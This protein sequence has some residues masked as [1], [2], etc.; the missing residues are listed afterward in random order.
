MKKSIWTA[1]VAVLAVGL[2]AFAVV[3]VLKPSTPKLDIDNETNLYQGDSSAEGTLT[4]EGDEI[5]ETPFS[6]EETGESV[7]GEITSAIDNTITTVT[8]VLSRTTEPVTTKK[9]SLFPKKDKTTSQAPETSTAATTAAKPATTSTTRATTKASTTAKPTETTTVAGTY[10]YSYAGFNPTYIEITDANWQMV[11]VNRHYII[12][13][14]YKPQLAH[15]VTGDSNSKYLDY[16][17]APHYNEMYLAAAKDGIYLTT[18]SGY[19]SYELQKNNFE[20]KINKY[21]NQG[22]TRVAAT[23]AAAKII[24]PPGTSEHNAGLA[25]DIIS[26]EQSFENSKAFKW[27]QAHAQDYGFI[28]RYPK[29]KEAITEI[30]YEPWHWRYVGV[31]NARKIK[32]SGLC[33]EEYLGKTP[34]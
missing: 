21:I 1:A 17:V 34:R 25:M 26:L 15:A 33:L 3:K 11:L 4:G 12:R 24:L 8:E 22:Y 19:R 9:N 13:K 30:I 14:D 20:N 29:D 28:L 32:A 10:E 23:Q 2:I 18:V 5:S 27:L 16:R 7:I 6:Q 31:E